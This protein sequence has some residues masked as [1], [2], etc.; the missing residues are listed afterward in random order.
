MTLLS[1][2]RSW[3][4]VIVR[5][6]H[7]ESEMDAELRFHME[8]YAEE[9]MRDG[10][11][12]EEALRRARI[13]FGGIERIKEEGRE[14]RGANLIDN[15]V[16]DL[17]YGVRTLRKNPGF[18][19]LVVLILGLG[20]GANAAVFSVLHAVLLRPLPYK[21]PEQ[22]TM[23]WVTDSR[24]RGWA[25]T[26]GSTSYR[27]FLE[28]RRQ[29]HTFED[30]AIFYKRGWSVVTL[31]GEEPEK[32]QGAFVSANFF[33]LMGVQPLVG[34]AFS[35]ED[36][37]H[38]ER[39]VILSHGLWQSRFGGS[40][41]ALGHDIYIDGKPWRVVG[42]MPPQFRFPFLAGN[43]ENR[44]E[45]EVQ[46]WAPLTTNPYEEPWSSD[47]FNLMRPQGVARFQVIARLNPKMSLQAAQAE[48]DTIAARLALQ[49]PD[50]DK[51]LGVQVR[52]LN[53][54]IAGKMRRPLLLL[55]LC[56]LLLLL[57]A[58]T[59]LTTLFLA[60][61]I[62]RARELAVRAAI[63]AT[64]WRVIRQL[65]TESVLLAII[66]GGAGVLLA[67][68]ALHLIVSLSPLTV[69]RLD[70]T[71][72]D[73]AVLVFSFLLSLLCGLGFGL[74]PAHRFSAADPHELLKTGQQITAS[75]T[76]RM[77]GLLVGTQFALSL[78]L[79]AS[80]GLLIRSFVEVLALDPGF[81]PDHILT[82][83]VQFANPDATPPA[84]LADYYQQAWERLH[85]IPGVQAVGTVGNIFFL[86]ENQNHALRQVEG[87]ASEP[88][89]S[90]TPLVWTQVSG[91]YFRAMAIP[92]LQGRYFTPQDGP[93]SPPVAIINQTLAKRYW[94]GEDPIGN[95]LKGFD[96]RGRNDEWV[97]VV[98]LVADMRSHGLERLPMAEIYE[99]QAQRGEATPNLIVRISA[100]PMQLAPTI[101]GTL[102]SLDRSV[103]LSGITT[104]QDVL[105]EQTAA[106]RF[107]A[108]LMGVFSALALLLAAVGVYGVMYYFVAQRTPEIGVRMAFGA[109]GKD[110]VSLFMR[111]AMRFAGAG[112]AVGLVLALWSASLIKRMLFG[113]TNTD[114]L[115]FLGALSLLILV[116]LIAT[117]FPARRATRVDPMVALRYE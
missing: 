18:T 19:V 104:M 8:E 101:R 40:L 35:D 26:D 10:V 67:G 23:L 86:E 42:V 75:S 74:A 24:P 94:P 54:Y 107:Q 21:S 71:R 89:D 97:T 3:L 93:E 25:V 114:P 73:T 82:M 81:Q 36:L 11:P 50:A 79:L 115:S 9:L 39:V 102:R 61:G 108:W 80:A 53:E 83:K 32:V 44:V 106:R 14:A 6:S 5:R 55:S 49:Y 47:P 78:V 2:F 27:D 68:P 7:M 65:L 112:L 52:R 109:C 59:N 62:A 16:Q 12:R 70:E 72:I 28:W 22:L 85:K 84:R 117:Y 33:T 46:L 77:Q 92:L 103:I 51:T 38:R 58:C 99:V 66:A 88:V 91:D 69:P 111:R 76:L 43:W 87:H 13:E 29:A 113:V 30:L 48:M 98:G 1:R 31:T 116:A 63:G 95:R 34:R 96:P 90:W 45:G 37:Q 64:R 20:I 56:V 105:R 60:R 110:I 41:E 100:D 15:L 17:R 4:R 57:L